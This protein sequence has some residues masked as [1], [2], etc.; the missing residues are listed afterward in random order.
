MF[1]I[2]YLPQVVSQV[3]LFDVHSALNEEQQ[4]VEY[5]SSYLMDH[6]VTQIAIKIYNIV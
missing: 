5:Y 1:L 3:K 6:P 4:E 2:S